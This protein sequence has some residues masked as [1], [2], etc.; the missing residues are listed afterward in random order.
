MA[1]IDPIIRELVQEAELTR[2]VLERIPEDKLSWKPHPSSFSI[3]QLAWHVATLPAFIAN[4]LP[5]EGL[6]VGSTGPPNPPAAKSLAE[7][8]SALTKNVELAS[9]V[10]STLDDQKI[11]APWK[12]TRG[13]E[14]LLTLPRIAVARTIMLNHIYHHRGQLQVYLRLLGVKVPS[15]YGPSAD[16]NPFTQA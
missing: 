14:V 1:L 6:D 12:L 11:T 9:K 15:I 7:L 2:K 4:T 8:L 13:G 16:E 5:N 10:L 3:G